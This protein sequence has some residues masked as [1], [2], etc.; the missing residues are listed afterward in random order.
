MGLHR[1]ACS[2]EEIASDWSSQWQF[3]TFEDEL[4]ARL[5]TVH[6]LE[7]PFSAHCQGVQLSD[8]NPN[9]KCSVI[10]WGALCAYCLFRTTLHMFLSRKVVARGGLG[11]GKPAQAQLFSGG[12]EQ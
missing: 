6:G 2:L 10:E 12:S 9:L 8:F 5:S 3:S 11:H 4:A 1:Y 7:T